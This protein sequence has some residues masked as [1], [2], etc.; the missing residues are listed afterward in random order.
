MNIR[1]STVILGLLLL[2]LPACRAHQ[3]IRQNPNRPLLQPQLLGGGSDLAGFEIAPV[4][5]IPFRAI[6]EAENEVIDEN[7]HTSIE[8]LVTQVARDS[9]GRTRADIDLNPVGAT[10]PNPKWVSVEIHDVVAKT[11][12]TLVPWNKVA[13]RLHE[14]G[15]SAPAAVVKGFSRNTAPA[16]IETDRLGLP[17]PPAIESRNEELAP[18]IVEGMSVRY[19]RTTTRYPAGYAGLKEGYTE[20]TEYWYSQELQAY[21]QVKQTG[22]GNASRILKLRDIRREDSAI[23]LFRIPK[24]YK[25]QETFLAGEWHGGQGFCP[26]P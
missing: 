21:V 3:T 13:F 4:P 5:G 18:D 25:T 14:R 23:S 10:T 2:F 6:I 16:P 7:G 17:E 1:H 22:R 11:D 24:G 19:G 20:V 9:R 15:S 26:V 8:R 12:I